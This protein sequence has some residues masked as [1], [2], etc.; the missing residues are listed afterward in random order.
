MLSSHL[1]KGVR[2]HQGNSLVCV[3]A[4]LWGES[5]SEQ[6]SSYVDQWKEVLEKKIM[7]KSH[8]HEVLA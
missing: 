1:T 6:T 2:S 8:G 3:K 7:F 5:V 4:K